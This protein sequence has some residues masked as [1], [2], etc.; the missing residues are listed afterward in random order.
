MSKSLKSNDFLLFGRTDNQNNV[1]RLFQKDTITPWPGVEVWYSP[2]IWNEKLLTLTYFNKPVSPEQKGNPGSNY[3]AISG[4]DTIF[5]FSDRPSSSGRPHAFFVV[6]NKWVL[7]AEESVFINGINQ[8]KQFGFDGSFGAGNFEDK[9]F[10][11]FK[12]GDTAGMV[13]DGKILPA[14][15]N[16]I[17][18]YACCSDFIYNPG[19]FLTE[20]YF[21]G[22]R[23]GVWYRCEYIGDSS[24]LRKYLPKSK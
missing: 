13:W 4:K 11:F 15:Y 2:L 7:E 17:P 22:R 19:V 24:S 10:Y 14:R 12:K 21:F 23:G 6:K 9:I 20:L 3:A 18:H 5:K 16:R 1:Y 8:N